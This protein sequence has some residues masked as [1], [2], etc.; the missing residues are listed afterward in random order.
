MIFTYLIAT[1]IKRHEGIILPAGWN[2]LLRG[3]QPLTKEQEK[4]KPQNPLPDQLSKLAY[5]MVHSAEI[6]IPAFD[7]IIEDFSAN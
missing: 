3:A 4:D 1:G 5:D 6:L 2:L 7:G